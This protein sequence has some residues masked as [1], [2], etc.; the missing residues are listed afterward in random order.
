MDNQAL[1]TRLYEK[2]FEEQEKYRGWLLT[3]PPEEILNHTYEYTVREDILMSLEYNDLTDAQVKALLSSPSPL[4]EV[5]S[6]FENIETS[7]MEDIRD[8]IESRANDVI[9]AQRLE[10][11]NAPVYPYP[12]A[13]AREHG[14]LEQYRLSNK[15]NVACKEA[16][17]TAISGNYRNNCLDCA[18]VFKQVSES[19][20]RDRIVFVLANTVREKDWDGRLSHENKAWAKTVPVFEDKDHF[21]TN[22]NC[23][24]VVDQAHTGLVD[25]FVT[26]MRKELAKEKEQPQK[27]SSVLAQLRETLP[28]KTAPVAKKKEMEL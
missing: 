2:M 10:L 26:H 11:L 4:S 19:F 23:Y 12:A 17:E 5:F 28:A 7:H 16:L 1:N 20:S 27:K 3:Q 21:G 9:E 6:A 24:F 25:L 18:S 13:Y 22:R 14:E 15:A 8:C